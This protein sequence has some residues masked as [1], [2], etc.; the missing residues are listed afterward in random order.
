[1]KEPSSKVIYNFIQSSQGNCYMSRATSMMIVLLC[2]ATVKTIPSE[3]YRNTTDS[4]Q[5]STFELL[6]NNGR[7]CPMTKKNCYIS[8]I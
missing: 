4:I 1:M 2:D 3:R 5:Y 6:A 7:N 8:L